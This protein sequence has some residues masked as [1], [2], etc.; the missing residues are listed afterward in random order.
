[1]VAGTEVA[2]RSR[3]RRCRRPQAE[4]SLVFRLQPAAPEKNRL[5]AKHQRWCSGFSR[6]PL[7]RIA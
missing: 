1:M 7:K 4:R 2:S 6:L 5:K 3:D